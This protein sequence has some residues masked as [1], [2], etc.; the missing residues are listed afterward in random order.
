MPWHPVS[1]GECLSVIADRYG[2][3]W[4]DIWEHGNNEALRRERENPDVLLP[5]DLLYI[6][7]LEERTHGASTGRRH[8]AQ[9]SSA[10]GWI[11]LRLLDPNQQ[12]IGNRPY[13]LEFGGQTRTGRTDQR[14]DLEIRIPTHV[15]HATLRVDPD[16]AV[17]GGSPT[18][19][20]LQ[21]GHLDPAD[22]LTGVQARLNALGYDAGPVDGIFGPRTKGAVK[23]FQEG[24]H[25]D[26]DGIPG[27][28]TQGK[29]REVY[30]G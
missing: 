16:P 15:F 2:F 22:Y 4:Q 25:L 18:H 7:A 23:R 1:Q 29:L 30:G 14:G 17:E 26:V 24:Y 19:W 28:I 8:R 11:S 27:P 13:T 20:P 6:P 3:R 12:P 21:I 9:R 10:G 5:G